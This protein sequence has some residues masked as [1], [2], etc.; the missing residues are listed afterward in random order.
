MDQEENHDA[1]N[2]TNNNGSTFDESLT[3]WQRKVLYH[4]RAR[5]RLSNERKYLGWLRLSLGMVT[6]GFVVERL[7]LLLA[8]IKDMGTQKL[9]GML[10]WAPSVLYVMGVVTICIATWEYFAD[11]RQNMAEESRESRLLYILILLIL[12]FVVFI[13]LLLWLPGILQDL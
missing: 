2:T 6:L 11:R 4:H 10:L 3:E 9:P 1:S 5:T 7:D 8:R 12:I 13:A